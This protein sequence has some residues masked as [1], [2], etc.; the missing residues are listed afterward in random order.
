MI[1]LHT[2]ILPGFDDGPASSEESLA[3]LRQAADQGIT[4][5]V[6]SPH[7]MKGSYDHTPESIARGVAELQ[8]LAQAA[9]IPVKLHV[10]GEVYL[11]FDV[12]EAAKEQR[13]ITLGAG[14]YVLLEF[15]AMGLPQGM[16]EIVFELQIR[17]YHPILAHPERNL[18]IINKPSLLYELVYKGV[19][20]QQNAGA[21]L[22]Y[23][24]NSVREVARLFLEHHLVHAVASDAHDARQRT[25]CQREWVALATPLLGAD[26]VAQLTTTVPGAIIRG[27]EV[28]F[29]EPLQLVEGGW[30]QDLR[31]WWRRRAQ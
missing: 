13:A 21:L 8:A 27:E 4:E 10:G 19:L 6:A 12:L 24:G 20:V 25:F 16:D 3:M 22:G 31:Q 11:D 5:L 23:F 1:D 26:N 28:D 15:P 30:L 9:G 14:R 17:G 29:N 2:H 7:V 18:D